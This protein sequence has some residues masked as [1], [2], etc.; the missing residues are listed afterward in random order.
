M[1]C[2]ATT[3]PEYPRSL[4]LILYY[5]VVTRTPYLKEEVNRPDRRCLDL[6]YQHS[7]H[8]EL[9]CILV[10]P[11]TPLSQFPVDVIGILMKIAVTLRLNRSNSTLVQNCSVWDTFQF[12]RCQANWGFALYLCNL[13][14]SSYACND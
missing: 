10:L 6:C 1:A 7:I 8:S 14:I 13:L 4:E 11:N 3:L 5:P 2:E 12:R 9:Y